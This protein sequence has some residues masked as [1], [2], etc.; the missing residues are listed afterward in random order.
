MQAELDDATYTSLLAHQQDKPAVV[1][2]DDATRTRW[3]MFRG[4]FY[5][6]DEGYSEAEVKILILDRMQQK[7]RRLQR[8]R[9]RLTRS[10]ELSARRQAIPDD[11]K[12]F[13]WQRDN[14]CCVK[15]GSHERLEFDHIIPLCKGG[16]SSERNLQILCETCNRSKGGEIV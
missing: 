15:C 5:S 6:E 14:R 7:E 2:I 8:A 12:T 9:A 11:V 1:L 3:W 13:V 10:A 16:S 4:D